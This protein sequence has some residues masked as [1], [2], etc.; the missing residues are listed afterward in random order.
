[1]L[2]CSKII[3]RNYKTTEILFQC[4]SFNSSWNSINVKILNLPNLGQLGRETAKEGS[5]T[6][7]VVHT[8]DNFK[9]YYPVPQRWVP[10]KPSV[11]V[12]QGGSCYRKCVI[13]PN[14]IFNACLSGASTH[15][16]AGIR[17]PQGNFLNTRPITRVRNWVVRV[18]ENLLISLFHSAWA[19]E[20][21]RKN[22]SKFTDPNHPISD[23]ANNKPKALWV[24]WDTA[25]S[26]VMYVFKNLIQLGT[27]AYQNCAFQVC[28]ITVQFA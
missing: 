4:H 28:L 5:R 23:S 18:G 9:N 6:A 8:L 1:M 24:I 12:T 15:P 3:T 27:F 14:D 2:T 20:G 19:G 7:Y 11:F 17:N 16:A 25:K 10:K 22:R 21:E 13:E 26:I